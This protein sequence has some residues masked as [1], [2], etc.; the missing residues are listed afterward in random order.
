MAA[1]FRGGIH[2]VLGYTGD[3]IMG[4]IFS[5]PLMSILKKYY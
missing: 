1:G 4:F 2:V 3:Y 5:A